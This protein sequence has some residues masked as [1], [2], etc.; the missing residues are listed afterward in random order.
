MKPTIIFL[1]LLVV[2]FSKAADAQNKKI[3]PNVIYISFEDMWPTLGCYGD[4][5]I[6]SPNIDK[7]SKEAVLF[8]D[9]HCQV[10]LCTPSR[11]SILTGIRP[12]TSG[13]VKIDDNW[14]QFLPNATSLPRHFRN[15]GYYTA[16]A[17][18]IHD[19]RCGGMDSAYTRTYDIY[20]L[21][22]NSLALEALENA[23][24]QDKP[25]FLAIGY[26]S[27]HDP[28]TP[29]TRAKK[30]Y[31]SVQF[32]VEYRERNYKNRGILYSD[33]EMRQLVRDYYGEIT[34]LDSMVGVVLTKIKQ[35]GLFENSIILLGAMDHGFSLGYHGRWGKTKCYDE[36]THVPFMI[37]VP[38]NVNNG[39]RSPALVELVDIYPT[40]V[41]LCGLP[42]PQ[43][44][45]EGFSMRKLIENPQQTWKKAV[46]SHQA[47]GIDIVSVKTKEYNLI[48]FAGDS[49]RLYDRKRDPHNLFDLSAEKPEV[50][51]E[52][53]KIK[54]EGWKGVASEL[55]LSRK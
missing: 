42:Q 25:F 6:K 52:L 51:E 13:M 22:D 44:Q 47:Y 37:Y 54:D 27:A 9:V 31:S 48:Y 32:P 12:S 34:D 53:I 7:F 17:G 18:K 50:V 4:T 26:S 5:I 36:E 19:Y 24:S 41:E 30:I 40:L 45:L 11:T 3:R 43:Q 20:G 15:N 38:G 35:M 23:A 8:E 55:K 49:I 21:K 33:E 39:S 1:A 46:F 29:T 28:W 14:R 2:C 16:I 10:A